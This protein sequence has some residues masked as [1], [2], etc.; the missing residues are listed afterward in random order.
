M[1]DWKS[2]ATA[3]GESKGGGWKSR[4]SAVEPE[5]EKG[6]GDSAEAFLDHAGNMFTLGYGPQIKAGIEPAVGKIVGLLTGTDIPQGSYVERRDENIRK[7]QKADEEHPD[8]SL[9]GKIT[10]ALTG[11]VATP[12]PG[13]AAGKG[14][15]SAAGQGAAFGAG[16]GAL[17]NPGD[18]PGVVDPIQLEERAG[19]AISGALMGG[20]VGGGSRALQKG[21]EKLADSPRLVREYGNTKALKGAGAMLKDFR[22]ADA[23]GQV[24]DIGEFMNSRGLIKAGDTFEDVARK[25]AELNAESGGRLDT[26]YRGATSKFRDPNFTSKLGEVE[27]EAL[28][29]SGFNPVRDKDA[30]LKAATDALGDQE[31]AKRAIARLA[32]YMDDLGTKYGDNVLD[33]R[34]AN[35]IKGAID[36]T[37][38]YSRNPL[39]KEPQVETAF[40]SA[41][42]LVSKKIDQDIDTL[43]RIAGDPD[44]LKALKGAN[45]DYGFSKQVMNIADDRVSRENAN[46]MFGLTDTITGSAAGAVGGGLAGLAGGDASD[47]GKAALVTGLLGAIANK[48]ARTYGPGVLAQGSRI[49]A[50]VLKVTASPVGKVGQS[51]VNPEMLTRLI[52]ELT[53]VNRSSPDAI[54]E[55]A[56][57]LISTPAQFKDEKKGLIKKKAK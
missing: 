16:M 26:V 18:T 55:E 29:S 35:E 31:G 48:G 23:R 13:F 9:A 45:R 1:S 25:A 28:V 42:G 41:R 49:A 20:A 33:P 40:H 52:S 21:F 46:R 38:N 51:V 15:L 44:A 7:L 22:T 19:G 30:I 17:A 37:V 36:K 34:K 8:A 47:T 50:P 14:I 6:F 57:T 12:M 3:V 5:S 32:E 54:P 43:G 10:G 4:A 56:R 11:A 27:K 39:A 24:Q 53:S 2:R